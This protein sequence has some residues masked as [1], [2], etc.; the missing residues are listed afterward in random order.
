MNTAGLHELKHELKNLSAEELAGICLSLAR[1]KKDNKEYLAYLLFEAGSPENY[2]AAVKEKI[3]E[4]FMLMKGQNNLYYTKKSLR[5]VLRMIAKYS[6]YIGEKRAN[7]ELLIYFCLK[8][9]QSGIPFNESKLIVNMYEQQIKK[10]D[11]L[12][13]SLH[14][15]L[16]M[17]F[18]EDL[19][20]LTGL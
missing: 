17:D 10:I 3:N 5:K 14:E 4:D 7:L 13:A 8:L 11:S 19:E 15:D 2:I 9:R 18:A 16:R 20:K 6:K 12:L 1:Y